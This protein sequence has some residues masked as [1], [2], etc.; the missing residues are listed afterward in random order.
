MGKT[1][2]SL[3]YLEDKLPDAGQPSVNVISGRTLYMNGHGGILEL[4]REHIGIAVKR[5][6][7]SVRGTELSLQ[8]MNGTELVI[9]GRI[10][11]VEWE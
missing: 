7:I 2:T 4:G 10:G 1:G 11:S 5:G 6:R 8:A 3:Q 9:T